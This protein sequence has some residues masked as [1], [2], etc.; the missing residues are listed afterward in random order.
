MDGSARLVP[1][2][3]PFAGSP[4]PLVARRA[5]GEPFWSRTRHRWTTV[6][7]L[8]YGG[9]I[10]EVGTESYRL[11]QTRAR[12]EAGGAAATRQRAAE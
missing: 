6:D 7:R 5:T 12:A 8:T 4:S 1:V 9:N 10:I 2:T 11:A 3:G